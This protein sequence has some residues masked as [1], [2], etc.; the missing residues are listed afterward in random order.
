MADRLTKKERSQNMSRIRGSDTKPEIH[1]RSFLHKKGFRFR[2]HDKKLPGKP[3][4]VMNKYKTAVFVDGCYWHRHQGCKLAYNPKSRQEFWQS[5]FESNVRRDK[6]VNRLF[7]NLDWK[8]IRIWQC[9]I[10]E[11]NLT[12]LAR[13]I[14]SV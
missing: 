12:R 10:N 14:K 3:D 8:I 13:N 5:K 7:E 1:V 9:E 11:E 6:E 4:I 2:L